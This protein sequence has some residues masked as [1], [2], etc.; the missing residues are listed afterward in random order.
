M[1]KNKERIKNKDNGDC[2]KYQGPGFE[3]QCIS[4]LNQH[5][6]SVKT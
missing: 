3:S 2:L 1:E 4:A 6:S 5:M